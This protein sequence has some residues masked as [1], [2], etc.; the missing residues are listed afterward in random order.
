MDSL[1]WYVTGIIV[2]ICI[3]VA[4][5]IEGYNVLLGKRKKR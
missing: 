2:I 4:V 1:G 3:A 5:G